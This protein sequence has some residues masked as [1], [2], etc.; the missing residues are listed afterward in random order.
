MPNCI[1][2]MNYEF[3]VEDQTEETK[4]LLSFCDLDWDDNCLDFYKTHRQLNLRVYIK[5]ENPFINL[6]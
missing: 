4:K 6:Q 2:N 3:L 5:L 1:Y